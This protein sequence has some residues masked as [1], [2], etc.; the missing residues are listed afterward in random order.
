MEGNETSTGGNGI[1]GHD[2][3]SEDVTQT[4]TKAAPTPGAAAL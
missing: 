1:S 4:W 2:E 3:T